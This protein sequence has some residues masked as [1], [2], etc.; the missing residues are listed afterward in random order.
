M[1]M[2]ML[3]MERENGPV[4]IDW[5]DTRNAVFFLS[6]SLFHNDRNIA[7]LFGPS[8]WSTHSDGPMLGPMDL[9]CARYQM[10]VYVRAHRLPSG[11][12]SWVLAEQRRPVFCTL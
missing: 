6:L 3:M 1:M 8:S 4:A 11:A 5:L 7:D 12:V 2:I 10:C 9:V